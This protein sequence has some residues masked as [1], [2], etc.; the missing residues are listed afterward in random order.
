M[1]LFQFIWIFFVPSPGIY[2]NSPPPCIS[3]SQPRVTAQ[4]EQEIGDLQPG[5]VNSSGEMDEHLGTNYK[6]L[7][8]MCSIGVP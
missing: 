6:Y 4:L 3:G 8:S 2:H 5:H 1:P 7:I